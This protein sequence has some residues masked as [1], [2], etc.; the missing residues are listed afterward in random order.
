M[1]KT[2]LRSGA[3]LTIPAH[4]LTPLEPRQ[5]VKDSVGV[6][7][8]LL[9]QL[10]LGPEYTV[11]MLDRGDGK[12]GT[13]EPITPGSQFTVSDRYLLVD[14]RFMLAANMRYKQGKDLSSVTGLREMCPGDNTILGRS[15]E[16]GAPDDIPDS[17]SRKH[18][19]VAI[20]FDGTFTLGDC[21]STNNT[22]IML[23][24]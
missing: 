10:D 7:A 2:E 6:D 24:A 15:P 14:M 20:D 9:F 13:V 12:Q 19:A 4:R 11:F 16:Y 21:A 22:T 23:A 1:R 17:V 3:W 8:D 18:C 5:T